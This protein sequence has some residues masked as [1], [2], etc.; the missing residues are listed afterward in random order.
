MNLN[1]TELWMAASLVAIISAAGCASHAPVAGG[2][3]SPVQN[4]PA[5]PPSALAASEK[6]QIV[7]FAAEP[8]SIERG[9]RVTL[10]WDVRSAAEVQILPETGPVPEKGTKQLAPEKSVEYKLVARGPGG[11]VSATVSVNV[12]APK[13]AHAASS[14]EI[15]DVQAQ[16]AD[17][18]FDYDQFLLRDDARAELTQNAAVLRDFLSEVLGVIVRVEGHCDERGS[19]AYNTAM[20]ARRAEEARQFLVSLGLPAGKLEAVSYGNEMPLC[21][22]ATE[23]CWQ[24]NRRVHLAVIPEKTTQAALD[25]FFQVRR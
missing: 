17:I 20:G 15:T 13:I 12:I 22:E 21:T 2:R 16:L 6:P 25:R 1:R 5:A 3:P 11:E 14:K 18:H 4:T 10:A 24:K 23:A 8:P 7:H 19:A 9:Q